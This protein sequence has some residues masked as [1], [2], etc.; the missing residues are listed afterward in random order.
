[1]TS[2]LSTIYSPWNSEEVES[3]VVASSGTGSL[4][5]AGS[6]ANYVESSNL[7]DRVTNLP[8]V[9]AI[10]HLNV[11]FHGVPACM[12]RAGLC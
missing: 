2:K 12:L 9:K 6:I 10:R 5:G 7:Y 3:Y 11:F 8:V 1:M 4:N